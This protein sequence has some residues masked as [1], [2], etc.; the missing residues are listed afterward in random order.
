MV[1]FVRTEGYDEGRDKNMLYAMMRKRNPD[2]CL[3]L[4]VDE[5]F[6]PQLTRKDFDRLMSRSW[7]NKYG[8]R[9]FH[10]IDYE[11]FCRFMVSPEL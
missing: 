10:F 2:W 5:I 6:E 3:W 7:I 8:F 1:D 11:P 9:R 4:D